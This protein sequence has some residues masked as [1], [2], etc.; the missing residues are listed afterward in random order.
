MSAIEPRRR[1]FPCGVWPGVMN[2]PGVRFTLIAVQA[3]LERRDVERPARRSEPRPALRGAMVPVEMTRS[4]PRSLRRKKYSSIAAALCDLVQVPFEGAELASSAGNTGAL[5]AMGAFSCQ[6]V[7][8]WELPAMGRCPIA[9]RAYPHGSAG[10]PHASADDRISL[11]A[12][13]ASW[14]PSWPPIWR[15]A[16]DRENRRVGLLNIGE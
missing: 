12:G 4:S 15:A 3:D 1:A 11:A 2:S 14:D 10:A 6:D 8:G 16:H 5:M 13:S 9:R 7:P